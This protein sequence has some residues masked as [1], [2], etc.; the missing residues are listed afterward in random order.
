MRTPS[1]PL[2]EAVKAALA[3]HGLEGAALSVAFSGGYDSLCLL[4]VLS[5]VH[6]GP[7]KA[8]YVNH[9]IRSQ[10]ELSTEL[11]L[12]R[13]NCQR[14]G[15]PLEV[16]T[17]ERGAVSRR[18]QEDRVTTEAA[19]RALRY[20]VLGQHLPVATAHNR[21]DQVESLLMKL[22]QGGTLASLSGIRRYRDGIVRP[23][24]DVH[25]SEIESYVDSLGLVASHD[26]TNDEDFCL[27]NRVRSSLKGLLSVEEEAVLVR[28]ADNMQAVLD[29]FPPLEAED[30]GGAL[31]LDRQAFLKAHPV[32]RDGFLYE[33]WGRH[34]R[35]RLPDGM[36]TR[37]EELALKGGRLSTGRIIFTARKDVILVHQGPCCFAKPFSPSLSIPGG[38]VLATS[39]SYQA[40]RFD[41]G[42]LGEGAF[43]R[44]SEPG[45]VLEGVG[46]VSGLLSSWGCPYGLVVQTR[47]GIKAVFASAYGGRN[48]L[49]P[50]LHKDG[51]EGLPGYDLMA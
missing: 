7:L 42:D 26:S 41:P 39:S 8:I 25:R 43:V 32:S 50:S 17:L 13:A 19:A 46:P 29:R 9:N 33:V 30:L 49:S 20:E 22:V 10:E 27:R 3:R 38:L 12:N 44:F 1:M 5:R 37:I 4:A 51:W 36:R 18:A 28:I 47:E 45:D 35:G 16:V 6:K 11:A 14:L 21:D 15:V 34:G 40:L 23:L 24:L 48:R 31:R 2:E